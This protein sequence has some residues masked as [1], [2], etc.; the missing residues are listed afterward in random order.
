MKNKITLAFTCDE[1]YFGLLYTAIS[2][3][4]KNKA[5][6]DYFKIYLVVRYLSEKKIKKLYSLGREHF[7]LHIVTIENT[8]LDA[9]KSFP[10]E[11]HFT[12]EASFRLLFSTL[13]PQEEKILY[14]DP[15]IIVKTSLFPLYQ[16]DLSGHAVGAV[17]EVFGIDNSIRVHGDPQIKYFN[18]GIM[19]FDLKKWRENSIEQAILRIGHEKKQD[20]IFVDQDILNIYF[21][22]DYCILEKE[23]NSP[24]YL[25]DA[26]A[27]IIHFCGSDKMAL[28]QSD[29]LKSYGY[30]EKFRWK[31]KKYYLK[32]SL[33]AAFSQKWVRKFFTAYIS[34]LTTYC[35][36]LIP[37]QDIKRLEEQEV[38][39]REFPDRL[40]K[41][42]PFKGMHYTNTISVCSVLLPK[43][44][45]CYEREL[46]P[47]I[48]EAIA[49]PPQTI[50][51]IGCAEGYYAVGLARRCP[52]ANVFAFDIDQS[53]RK[54]CHEMASNNSVRDR[55]F[56]GSECKKS[57]LLAFSGMHGVII[58]DCEGYEI[59]LFDQT[60]A[61]ALSNF[62]LIIELHDCFNIEISKTL[63]DVFSGSH[64]IK[65]IHGIRDIDKVFLYDM[66]PLQKFSLKD[67]R[68]FVAEHRL[69]PMDWMHCI[70]KQPGCGSM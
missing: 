50:I 11:Y 18:S 7:D 3:I 26:N 59:S 63:N 66:D 24:A 19:L 53:A 4:I 46:H 45:G 41:N 70:P 44:I 2:S 36:S 34:P 31:G 57:D 54:Y 33:A 12:I 15:D 9:I 49:T 35:Q 65:I 16:T 20:L 69:E 22:N 48:E 51:D 60:T 10:L 43:L 28:P 5:R 6:D 68:T 47:V 52:Q 58:C 1:N 55:L 64:D 38:I 40:V 42:G 8:H 29:L 32:K 25:C 39:K 17:P 56:I 62:H 14:L 37:Q 67:R 61:S 23:W 21:K 13:I 30:K 27:K